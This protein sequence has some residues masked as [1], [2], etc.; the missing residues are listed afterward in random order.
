VTADWKIL[1]SVQVRDM[2]PQQILFEWSNSK[3]R[4]LGGGRC[5]RGGGANHRDCWWGNLKERDVL[6]NRGIMGE[7]WNGS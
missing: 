5:V 7:Y 2:H 1:H 3:M 6:E 4:V